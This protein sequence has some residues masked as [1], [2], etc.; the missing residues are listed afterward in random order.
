MIFSRYRKGHSIHSPF[1]Y[2]FV[3][4]VIYGK[5]RFDYSGLNDLRQKLSKDHTVISVRDPGAGSKTGL[6]KERNI[7]QITTHTAIKTKYG[8]LLTRLAHWHAPDTIIEL[9]TGIGLST[10]YLAIGGRSSNIMT[11]EGIEEIAVMAKNT[12]STMKLTNVEIHQGLFSEKLP[13]V[14]HNIKDKVLV[15]ID[16][17]HSRENLLQYYSLIREY[18]NDDT[19]I[20]IDDIYWSGSMEMAWKELIAEPEVSI[21]IDLFQMGILFFKKG[22]GKQHYVMRY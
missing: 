14:L 6:E 3:E 22:L 7:S 10:V 20:V 1:V 18:S 19:V 9:G 4:D 16:G 15:F 2:G 11:I 21:S 13:N 5:D 17:D 12:V 8:R